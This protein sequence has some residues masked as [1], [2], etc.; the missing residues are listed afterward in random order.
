MAKFNLGHLGFINYDD[1][2]NLQ[3][4]KV[5]K[6]D[7]LSISSLSCLGRQWSTANF[8]SNFQLT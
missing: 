2:V 1:D 5:Y 3:L 6:A 4:L 8:K 7:V